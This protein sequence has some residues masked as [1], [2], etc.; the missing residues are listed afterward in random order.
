MRG[1][2]E[3]KNENI[4]ILLFRRFLHFVLDPYGDFRFLSL[5]VISFA[6][7]SLTLPF[8]RSIVTNLLNLSNIQVSQND[9]IRLFDLFKLSHCPFLMTNQAFLSKMSGFD[10]GSKFQNAEL[11]ETL[12]CKIN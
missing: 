10:A 12:R 1:E 8:V 9:N 6:K 4:Q 7:G 2:R 5:N 11:I 3:G